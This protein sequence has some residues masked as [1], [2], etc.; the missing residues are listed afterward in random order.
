M[1]LAAVSSADGIFGRVPT[2]R[3]RFFLTFFA[4]F[5]YSN[6]FDSTCVYAAN[7]RMKLLAL[8]SGRF[9]P[10]GQQQKK[11]PR[12][13]FCCRLTTL[14]RFQLEQ[15]N[16]ST[17]SLSPRS[18]IGSTL[19]PNNSPSWSTAVKLDSSFPRDS[20]FECFELISIGIDSIFVF[21]FS[22]CLT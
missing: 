5:F 12:H 3:R 14:N 2:C 17:F 16:V 22:C 6:R 4:L 19:K 15:F 10:S 20:H 18:K 8:D 1:W 7:F 11:S 9:F 13:S 21:V